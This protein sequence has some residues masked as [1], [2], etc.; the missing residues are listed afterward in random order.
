MAFF[1]LTSLK[2][3]RGR[4]KG[5]ADLMP[6]ATLMGDGIVIN[7]DGSLLTGWFFRG[8]DVGS[9]LEET[10]A[11]IAERIN[12]VLP[13]LGD[14]WVF[15]FQ[16]VRMPAASY[17]PRSDA[18]FTAQ[19]TALMDDERRAIFEAEGAH[20][21]TEQALLVMYRPPGLHKTWVAGAVVSGDD[22]AGEPAS[23]RQIAVFERACAAI[24]DAMGDDLSM[25]RMGGF[26]Y[27]DPLGGRHHQD[28]LVNYLHFCVTGNEHGINIPPLAMHLDGLIGGQ[29]LW[30]GITPKIGDRFITCVAIEGFPSE[31]HPFILDLLVDQPFAYRVSMRFIPLS[32]HTAEHQINHHRRGWRQRIRGFRQ[33][34]FRTRDGFVNEDAALM[35][36]QT[37]LA[38]SDASS[39]LV[40]FGYY[41]PVI[42]LMGENRQALQD[43][44]RHLVREIGRFGFAARVETVN[45]MEAWLGTLP[46]HVHPDIRRPVIHSL[47]YAHLIPASGRWTG[48]PYNPSPLFPPNSPPLLHMSTGGSTPFRLNLHVGDVGHTL[49]LGPTGAGKSTLLADMA[50]SFTRYPRAQV[51]V[52][53]KGNSIFALASSI[54]ATGGERAAAHYTLA[55][56]DSPGLCPLAWLDTA[57]DV[58]WAEE[59]LGI[60]YELQTGQPPTPHQKAAIHRAIDLM[61]QTGRRESRSLT[62]FLTTV[63]DEDLRS[64]LRS[65]TIDGPL[66]E[67]LD[68]RQD[69]LAISSFTAFELGE[70][71]TRREASVIP[72]L[73]YLFR[74]FEQSLTGAPALLI[75]DEAW[76][77]LG[78]P[79]FREKIREW[80]KTLRKANC[81][82][83]M[84]T[85]SL[86]DAGR[87]GLLDVL[88]ESCATRL[89]LANPEALKRGSGNTP[90]P[91]DHYTAFGLNAVQ[92]GT[93]AAATPKRQVYVTS[94][95]GCRLVNHDIGPI[96]L[97]LAGASSAEDVARIKSLRNTHH[98][99]WAW[100]WL[101]EK[102]IHHER[103]LDEAA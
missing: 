30:S 73:L 63:Q 36:R 90:G 103:N 4:E 62:D 24:E 38:M 99:A 83:V 87:S 32:A 14:G 86:S 1:G 13:S 78:H 44:A 46:G 65:Y 88:L 84:A 17:P 54:A 25:R 29:E 37:E 76:L 61:R 42:V 100:K 94:P 55:G 80:L 35:A 64:A 23:D 53:D 27:E 71:M 34:L 11:R 40:V 45:T 77:M 98:D 26:D 70:L 69:D 85:Q 75:L 21:E 49:L 9:S 16:A 28:E 8:P 66:G 56:D 96:V 39:G 60:C 57:G 95:Q 12:R 51:T 58:A 74:R 81:A 101:A 19:I 33:Q 5:V 43:Q 59:W 7:K 50:A 67:L 3:F 72:P 97:A 82:V 22:E 15:W 102:G 48:L 68:A 20:F 52:F 92:I 47:N 31:S 6:W 89:F 10:Q 93:I 91:Y 79:V 18:H 2:P 41:T